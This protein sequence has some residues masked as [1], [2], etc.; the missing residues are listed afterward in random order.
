MG[1]EPPQ[2]AAE[3]YRQPLHGFII[4]DYDTPDMAEEESKPRNLGAVTGAVVLIAIVVGLLCYY[5]TSSWLLAIGIPILIIGA[6]ELISS[7]FRNTK[8]DQFGT[9]ESGAAALW[10]FL[11]IAVGGAIVIYPYADS[12]IIPIVFVLLIIVASIIYAMFKKKQA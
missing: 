5:V 12:I 6:Y 4:T 11:F 7:F 1:W 3:W 2:N 10:G 9:N 8:N